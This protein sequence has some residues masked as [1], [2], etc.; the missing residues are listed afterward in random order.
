[1]R[2]TGYQGL[3]NH[4]GVYIDIILLRAG[5]SDVL[6]LF[7]V[8]SSAMVPLV[9]PSRSVWCREGVPGREE[10]I[11]HRL[12]GQWRDPHARHWTQDLRCRQR[13]GQNC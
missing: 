5:D 6:Y 12:V 7:P 9:I 13:M 8:C 10:G 2:R 4:Q 1:M 11:E 3:P